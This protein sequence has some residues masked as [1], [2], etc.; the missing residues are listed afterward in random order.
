MK[1]ILKT[2]VI[3]LLTLATFLIATNANAQSKNEIE[4]TYVKINVDGLS[5]PFCAYGLEKKLKKIKTVSDI[6]IHLEEGIAVFSVSKNQKPT[7]DTLKK[8]VTDAGFTP[9]GIIFSENVF[10]LKDDE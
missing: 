1:T 5:C 2:G 9:S 7:K 8:I 10:K 4:K 3:T 6:E